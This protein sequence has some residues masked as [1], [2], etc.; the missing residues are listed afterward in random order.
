VSE[1]V[2]RGWSRGVELVSEFHGVY[3]RQSAGVSE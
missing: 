2:I 1:Y 3:M